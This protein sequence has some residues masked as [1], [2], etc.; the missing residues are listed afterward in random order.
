[1]GLSSL[2]SYRL[3]FD[4]IARFVDFKPHRRMTRADK[5][6]ITRYHT[7]ISRALERGYTPIKTRN[8]GRI[9]LAHK[10]QGIR[11]MP[12]LRVVLVKPSGKGFRASIGKDGTI[13]AVNGK[14]GLSKVTIGARFF[15]AEE[16]EGGDEVADEAA[17]LIKAAKIAL[18]H[19]PQRCAVAYWGG[20]NAWAE[21]SFLS[22]LLIVNFNQYANS[23]G[24]PADGVTF[25]WI[26]RTKNVL[27]VQQRLRDERAIASQKRAQ[28]RK[29][30]DI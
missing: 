25:Y 10:A 24:F 21:L 19:R 29:K 12:S 17:R 9:A 14:S 1:M 23:R 28:K 16:V 4:A 5:S 30:S 20:E 27:K 6:K 13:R 15:D 3:K 2:G 22:D 8:D 18:G 11:G 7:R 26:K